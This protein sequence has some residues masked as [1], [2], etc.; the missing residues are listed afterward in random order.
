MASLDYKMALAKNGFS[1]VKKI[2]PG[3]LCPGTLFPSCL[4]NIES[5]PSSHKKPYF[6]TLL[7]QVPFLG[8]YWEKNSSTLHVHLNFV[9]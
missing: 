9:L 1:S 6:Y 5:S 2:M 7:L 8:T 3:S 4:Q